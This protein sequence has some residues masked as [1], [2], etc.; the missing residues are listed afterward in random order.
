MQRNM[1][2]V[3][4]ADPL[5]KVV[6]AVANQKGGVGK[7]NVAGNVA[8]ELASRGLRVVAIDLDP[9][10]TLTTWLLGRG[11]WLGTED[12]LEG[13]VKLRDALLEAPAFGVRVLPSVPVRMR[14]TEPVLAAKL[15]NERML[16]R[17]LR[18]L[19]ADV[20][21][22][23][24]PPSM[25]F[26]THSAIVASTLVLAPVSPTVEALDGLA[27]LRASLTWFAETYERPFPLR[28]VTTSYDARLRIAREAREAMPALAGDGALLET[29]IRENVALREAVGHQEPIRTY[30][31][32][33]SGAL[34]YAALTTEIFDHALQLQ[35]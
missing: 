12:V 14:E 6:V 18:G 13:K 34:D 22:L 9:Q 32:T 3:V 33:S 17:A 35:A 31:P 23:D 29:A 5:P 8:A 7:T 4:K 30:R 21:L 2:S 20:V 11:D 10:A 16:E 1:V 28:V 27:Q 15:G 26:F 25:G 24:C 19:D